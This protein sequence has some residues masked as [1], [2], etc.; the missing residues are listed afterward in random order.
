[1]Q[2]PHRF[3]PKLNPLLPGLGTADEREE[4]AKIVETIPEPTTIPEREV[5][6][7]T[8]IKTQSDFVL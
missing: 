5:K 8:K 1:M 2:I 3:S 4:L 7:E 6:E